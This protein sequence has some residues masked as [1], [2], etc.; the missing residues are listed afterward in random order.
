MLETAR[1]LLVKEIALA[2]K[3]TEPNVEAEIESIF[4]EKAA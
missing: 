2:R 1:S 3:S 4:A